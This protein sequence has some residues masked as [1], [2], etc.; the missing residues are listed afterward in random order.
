MILLIVGLS[1]SETLSSLISCFLWMQGFSWDFTDP[2]SVLFN[3]V[4]SLHCTLDFCTSADPEDYCDTDAVDLRLNT[5]PSQML[6]Y[7][8]IIVHIF[9][10]TGKKIYIFNWCYSANKINIHIAAVWQRGRKAKN[11]IKMHL[12][13]D[14]MALFHCMVRH[15]TVRFT[16]GG[17]STGYCT[18]YLILF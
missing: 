11:N 7:G 2:F 6:E 13:R 14:L 16:F 3:S 12:D 4:F 1:K 9:A 8:A 17:F 10:N 18:W 5:V 15:G